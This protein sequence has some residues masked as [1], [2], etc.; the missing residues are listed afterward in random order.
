MTWMTWLMFAV[1]IAV[2]AAL[3]G[4]TP[5]D[6]RHVAGTRLMHVARVILALGV[7]ALF[8]FVFRPQ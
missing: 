5:K 8:Y 7:L 1:V 3:T 2:F 6:A 4:L